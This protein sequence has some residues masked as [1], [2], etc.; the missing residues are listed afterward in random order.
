MK[1][2]FNLHTYDI[3]YFLLLFV[4]YKHQIS[5][6]HICQYQ[7]LYSHILFYVFLYL[8][9]LIQPNYSSLGPLLSLVAAMKFI[10]SEIFRTAAMFIP[11]TLQKIKS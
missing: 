4:E 7:I 9:S 1:H 6:R 2:S 3:Y 11:K 5:Y 8:L 10:T